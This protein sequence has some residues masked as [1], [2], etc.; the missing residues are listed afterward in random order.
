MVNAVVLI[1]KKN[2]DKSLKAR[3][4]VLTIKQT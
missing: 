2:E 4:L 1:N 3:M